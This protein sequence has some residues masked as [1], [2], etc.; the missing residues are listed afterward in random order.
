MIYDIISLRTNADVGTIRLSV[1]AEET[2]LFLRYIIYTTSKYSWPTAG[3]LT[4]HRWV[5]IRPYS[6]PQVNTV[7]TT[8]KFLA[9][10]LTA[11]VDGDSPC[12][13]HPPGILLAWVSRQSCM[14]LRRLS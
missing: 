14:G 8:V 3:I 10:A 7:T 5:Y 12:D 2:R 9:L 4:N 1:R 13:A 6:Y 11:R